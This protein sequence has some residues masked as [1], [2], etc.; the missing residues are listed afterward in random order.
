MN[1]EILVDGLLLMIVGI[2]TVF[3]FLNI[4]M[5]VMNISSRIAAYFSKFENATEPELSNAYSS[6][7]KK[8][9]SQDENRDNELQDEDLIAVITAAIQQYRTENS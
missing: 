2:S 7:M 4:M 8:K 5:L 3:I 9:S 1:P 6:R